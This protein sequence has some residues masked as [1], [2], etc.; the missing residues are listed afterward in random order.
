MGEDRPCGGPAGAAAGCGWR[1]AGSVGCIGGGSWD[2]TDGAGWGCMGGCMGD[3]TCG[4]TDGGPVGGGAEEGGPVGEG[5][6]G[7]GPVGGGA[8]EEGPEREQRKD[9]LKSNV[10]FQQCSNVNL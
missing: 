1:G 5:P 2:W 8:E 6:E 7:G 9:A 4:L 3:G 10:S